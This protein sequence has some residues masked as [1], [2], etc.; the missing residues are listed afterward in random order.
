MDGHVAGTPAELGDALFGALQTGSVDAVADLL[1]ETVIFQHHP[2]P[3]AVGKQ[4]VLKVVGHLAKH[5][6]WSLV[7]K[8]AC[9]AD[10]QV[11]LCER[12]ECVR[13]IGLDLHLRGVMVLHCRDGYIERITDHMDLLHCTAAGFRALLRRLFRLP[14]PTF[15]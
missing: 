1:A 6:Q 15:S 3:A 11:F 12:T 8:H 2:L 5:A 7:A 10:A 4:K 9:A 14:P 13:V